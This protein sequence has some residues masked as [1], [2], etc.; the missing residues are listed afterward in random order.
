[1]LEK[2]KER[3]E[4]L[5]FLIISGVFLLFSLGLLII[6]YVTDFELSPYIDF[7]WLTIV[8]SGLPIIYE[9]VE[10][11]VEDHKISSELLISIAIIASIVIGE[12]FAAGEV[13][14]I[15]ALG[16]FLED[17]TVERAKKGLKNLID[18]TPTKANVL[19][20]ENDVERIIEKDINDVK[21]RDIVRILP[22]ETI[23]VDGEVIVGSSSI[24]QAV[25][26][27]E[28]MPVDVIPGDSVYAGT[29]N[30]YGS[31]DIEVSKEFED[32]SLSK[33]IKLLKE[34][35]E[36]QAPIGR[37]ADRWA[38]ILVPV[39]CLIAI[40]IGVITYIIIGNENNEAL[41]RGVT[42]LVVFCPCALSLATPTSIMAGIGQATKHGVL[43]KSGEALEAM[44]KSKIF[45][46]DKTGTLTYGTLS[47]NDFVSLSSVN[48]NEL[49]RICASIESR[50]EH[51]LG[52]AILKYAL[53]SNINVD[54]IDDFSITS[55]K[56]VSGILN[57]HK[58]YCGN[59]KYLLENNVKLNDECDFIFEKYRSDGKAL[60]LIANETEILGFVTLSDVVRATAKETIRK[61]KALGGKVVL[62]TGDNETTA[63]AIAKELDIDEIRA[64][65]LPEG[66]VEI[67]NEFKEKGYEVTMVGDGINDAP[68]LKT[69]SVGISLEGIGSNI[70]TEAAS[71]VL[72][73]DDIE[74]MPYLSLLSRA[75]VKTIKISIIMAL[76]INIIAVILSGFGILTPITGAIVH[77]VG[78]L[79]I[80]LNATFLY[81][82]NYYKKFNEI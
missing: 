13:A 39:S 62:L 64:N 68:A 50:S 31:I 1:M 14:F 15:M 18:I 35:E 43:I 74:K 48:E 33:M 53:E 80:I 46:F 51:P 27:G 73:N 57:N 28:S 12:V 20:I 61:L 77:N 42:V 40:L 81:D 66:K 21:I 41:I 24:N 55:G 71:I 69:S 59:E 10:S 44:G 76:L 65:L 52:K 26:T 45:C 22:G 5:P 78:S 9:A 7:A 36:N 32:S 70:T 34:T 29:N 6:K 82:K 75:T 63:K 38:S 67:I 47:V 60:V 11:I 23:P 2:I 72:L 17:I 4:S 30:L 56:G 3:F 25:L 8:I 49:L 54:K 16:E 19:K 79:L 58:Y 37:I